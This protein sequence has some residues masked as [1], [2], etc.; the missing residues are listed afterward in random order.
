MNRRPSDKCAP[1]SLSLGNSLLA[2]PYLLLCLRN[3]VAQ[4]PFFFQI[5]KQFGYFPKDAVREEHVH[6]TM[7]KVVA[8]QVN[9]L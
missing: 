5:D 3:G 8:T 6:A 2:C 9:R 1:P 4:F 7:E